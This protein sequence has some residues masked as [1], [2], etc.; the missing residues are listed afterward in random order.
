MGKDS[1]KVIHVR[2][3]LKTDRGD[4]INISLFAKLKGEPK[5]GAAPIE[6]NGQAG[7]KGLMAG[8]EA[9]QNRYNAAT[10]AASLLLKA[11]GG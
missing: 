7:A 3:D 8:Q 9:A 6:G 5:R 11:F 2:Y 4:T 1:N 10:N